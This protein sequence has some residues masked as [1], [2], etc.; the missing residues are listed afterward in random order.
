LNA[1]SSAAGA[2]AAQRKNGQ[3][4]RKIMTRKCMAENE[5]VSLKGV[6]RSAFNLEKVWAES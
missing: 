6:E 3:R 2:G 4:E 1:A 5:G